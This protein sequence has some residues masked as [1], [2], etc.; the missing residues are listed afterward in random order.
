M[1]A[2]RQD[3]DSPQATVPITELLPKNGLVYSEKAN[4]SEVRYVNRSTYLV[5]FSKL[6]LDFVA[7]KIY[8]AKVF[9]SPT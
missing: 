4:L 2:S 7:G 8:E 5:F 3:H 9:C 6:R 1:E